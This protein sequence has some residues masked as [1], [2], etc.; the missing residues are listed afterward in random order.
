MNDGITKQ[1]EILIVE[2][3][4]LMQE[5]YRQL[6]DKQRGMRVAEAVETT[7]EA[8]QLVQQHA[9]DLIIV[10]LALKESSGLD[11]VTQLIASDRE[12]KILVVST[13][14][15]KIFAQRVLSAG[16]RGFIN[17][18]A[19]TEVLIQAIRQVLD[20]KIFLSDAATQDVLHSATRGENAPFA[21]ITSLLSDREIQVFELLGR[22]LT[23]REIAQRIHLS[24]KT[25]ERYREN[26]KEKLNAR[27]A[28]DVAQKAVHWV[29][30]QS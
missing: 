6:I 21:D 30:E 22:G 24:R 2:D 12:R 9:Y 10:D 29:L 3:H 27:T 19:A 15:E 18:Q 16:A 5:G 7:D 20:G 14:S 23:V 8:Y 28:A 4:P 26:I 11:L 25:V 13:Y 1:A 17:K